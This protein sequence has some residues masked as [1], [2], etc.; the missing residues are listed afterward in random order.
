MA[1]VWQSF[2]I[3]K[4]NKVMSNLTLAL[5]AHV[6]RKR[7][8]LFDF[9]TRCKREIR[10]DK[11]MKG[12]ELNHEWEQFINKKLLEVW[13]RPVDSCGLYEYKGMHR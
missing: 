9:V 11:K 7:N 12:E 8:V 4:L 13:R 10:V 6:T 5:N 2:N 3:K 1:A